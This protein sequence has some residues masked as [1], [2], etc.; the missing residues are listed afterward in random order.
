LVEPLLYDLKKASRA[1]YGRFASY[2][3]SLSFVKVKPDTS[4]FIYQCGDDTVYLL[5]YVDYIVLMTSS[6]DLL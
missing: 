5:L 1:W 2:L 3:A 6:A 4:L